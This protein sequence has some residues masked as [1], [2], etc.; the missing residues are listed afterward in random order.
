M[1]VEEIMTQEVIT[2]GPDAELRD[3]AA[4][5]TER[6][7]SGLPVCD[8][9]RR[10]IGVVSEGDILVKEQGLLEEHHKLF[11]RGRR[12][13]RA[14]KSRAVTVRDAMTTPAI[15]ISPKCSVAEAARLMSEHYI[16]RLPVVRR[17][18]LVG[19][20]SR[21]DLVRAFVRSDDDIRHEIE[22]EVLVRTM[23]LEPP[24]AV[25]VDVQ[26]GTVHLTGRLDIRSDAVMLER[27]VERV[28]GVISVE[29][30][31]T[32]AVD[33]TTRRGQRELRAALVHDE[34]A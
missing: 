9:Q 11:D 10:V 25:H 16:N 8:A 24:S 20:V 14:R 13:E 5:L 30:A 2:I 18:E 27:L 32:W 3:V 28:P 26:R 33:D 23:W 29:A 31:L 22:D 15:T 12:A 7:I 6:H 1:K 17:D 34:R 21:T 4:I 19:I